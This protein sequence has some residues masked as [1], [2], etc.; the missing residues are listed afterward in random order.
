[1]STTQRVFVRR[2]GVGCIALAALLLAACERPPVDSVQRGVRGTG[3]VQV[4]NPRTVEAQIPANQPPAD[5]PAARPWV[6]RGCPRAPPVRA[7]P[8]HTGRGWS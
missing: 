7:A 1:M 5:Q 8:G 4:Y 2:L 6:T 3:M